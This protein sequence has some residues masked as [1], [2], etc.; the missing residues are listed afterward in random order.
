[1]NRIT[2]GLRIDRTCFVTIC[3]FSHH[4]AAYLAKAGKKVCVLER[5]GLIGGAAITE[6]LVPGFKFSRA[7]YVLSL[8]RPAVYED[9]QL[10]KHGLELFRRTPHSF[11]PL[12]EATANSKQTGL[13]LSSDKNV[14]TAEI[15]AFSARDAAKYVEYDALV[16]KCALAMQ[17]LLD[18]APVDPQELFSGGLKGY[19]RQWGAIKALW[20][21]V[22]QTGTDLDRFF[23]LFVA[24]ASKVT[25]CLN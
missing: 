6:S 21:A 5:R 4:Q 8:L 23:E 20:T 2:S 12:L 1:M 14:C 15:G 18:A 22:R 17:M 3:E 25:A 19:W 24:P 16:S 7:S 9:L 10:E 13:L 11:T